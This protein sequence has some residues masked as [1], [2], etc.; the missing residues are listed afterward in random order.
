MKIQWDNKF[1]PFKFAIDDGMYIFW[2]VCLVIFKWK[3]AAK[4][5]A[6]VPDRLHQSSRDCLG[7]GS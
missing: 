5:L 6:E 7:R 4:W 1:W 3:L 2:E